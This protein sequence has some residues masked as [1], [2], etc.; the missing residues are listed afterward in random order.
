MLVPKGLAFIQT[1]ECPWTW[2]MTKFGGGS[3]SSAFSAYI[4]E[5][6]QLRVPPGPPGDPRAPGSADL[7]G[8]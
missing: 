2:Y 7:K 6:R 8:F 3:S 4:P 5:L 1:E